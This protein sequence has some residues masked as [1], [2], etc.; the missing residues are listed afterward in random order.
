M[1]IEIKTADELVDRDLEARWAERRQGPQAEVLRWILRAFAERGGP[2][3]VSEVEAGFPEWPATAVRDE[4]ATLDE[5]DLILMAEHEIALA[6]PFSATPTAFAVTLA[7]GQER[8]ACCAIDALGIAA[9]LSAR[10]RIR[11]R[12]HHCEEP[13]ELAADATGPLGA[14]NVMVWVG[15]REAGERRVC[16]SL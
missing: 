3:P 10:I 2:I 4:L 1:P 12:C 11:T 7:D 9:M 15:K 8:F 14:G 16:T 13:L 5:K 6:Y